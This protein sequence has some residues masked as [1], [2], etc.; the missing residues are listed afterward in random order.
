MPERLTARDFHPEVLRLFD[1]YV[2][3]AIDRRAF[4]LGASRFTAGA[5]TAT[6]LLAALSPRFA[7]A[8]QVAPADPRIEARHVEFPAPDGNG[9]GRGYL[10]R[11]AAANGPLPL[12]LVIHENRG[13]NPHIED[14]AR[15]GRRR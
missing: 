10:V 8:Q 11:P 2:H 14:V 5:M 13:L 9:T 4:L 1:Q 15:R 6:G 12:V 7:A 3:G